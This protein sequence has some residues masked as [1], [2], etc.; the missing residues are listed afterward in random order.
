M[1]SLPC[2]LNEQNVMVEWLNGYGKYAIPS[3]YC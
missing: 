3:Y 1:A 2:P